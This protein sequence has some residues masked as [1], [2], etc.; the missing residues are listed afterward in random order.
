MGNPLPLSSWTTI[1]KL[2]ILAIAPFLY[3]TLIQQCRKIFFWRK[4]AES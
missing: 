4:G 2:S 3:H 1:S